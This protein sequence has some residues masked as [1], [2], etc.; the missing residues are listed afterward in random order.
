[1]QMHLFKHLQAGWP[2]QRQQIKVD[3]IAQSEEGMDSYYKVLQGYATLP[4]HSRALDHGNVM[5]KRRSN[6]D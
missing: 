4:S 2:S 6:E 1:M 5:R 3:C